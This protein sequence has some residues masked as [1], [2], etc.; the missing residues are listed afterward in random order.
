MT[1]TRKPQQRNYRKISHEEATVLVATAAARK[2]HM[3]APMCKPPWKA[4]SGGRAMQ[5]WREKD[6]LVKKVCSV[7]NPQLSNSTN[8][9]GPSSGTNFIYANWTHSELE[10]EVLSNG[11]ETTVPLWGSF[12]DEGREQSVISS[13][14]EWEDADLGDFFLPKACLKELRNWKYMKTKELWIKQIILHAKI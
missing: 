2:L 11:V 9:I 10:W 14:S 6:L 13:I 1:A 8:K 12:G 5:K 4:H 3:A 7:L